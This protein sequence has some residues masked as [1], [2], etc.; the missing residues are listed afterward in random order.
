VSNRLAQT[1]LTVVRDLRWGFGW[2]LSFA[3]VYLAWI[4]VLFAIGGQ[5]AFRRK[6]VTFQSTVIGYL[7]SALASG[8]IIGLLRPLNRWRAG[9][10]LSGFM[11]GTAI[12]VTLALLVEPAPH[13]GGEHIFAGVGLGLMSA[14]IAF[15][16][17][18]PDQSKV[19]GN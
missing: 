1:A 2:S 5:E 19:H 3:A 18:A 11:V 4:G 12:G 13:V 8:A 9:S 10:A 14:F 16:W 7:I 15:K 17:S 6:G